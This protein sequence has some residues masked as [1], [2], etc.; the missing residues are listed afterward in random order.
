MLQCY[1]GPRHL[2]IE[3]TCSHTVKVFQTIIAGC[4]FATPA[5]KMLLIRTG[6][7]A[8]LLHPAITLRIYVDDAS[9]QWLGRLGPQVLKLVKAVQWFVQELEALKLV[10]NRTKCKCVASTVKL[11]KYLGP[12][13]KKLQFVLAR[14]G[15]NLGH[16]IAAATQGRKTVGARITIGLQ[17]Q[18]RLKKFIRAAGTKGHRVLCVGLNASALY[19]ASVTGASEVEL[20]RHRKAVARAMAV[21]PGHSAT[22][23]MLFSPS[24]QLDPIF[25]AS[26]PLIRNYIK[27]IWGH[28][29][30]LARLREGWN[31][32][33]PELQQGATW[34]KA[35]GP[36]RAVALT[37]ARLG[38]EFGIL[39]LVS[40]TGRIFCPTKDPPMAIMEAVRSSIRQWQWVQ[41][42]KHAGMLVRD[43]WDAP[44]R[45]L[46]S[47]G[48]LTPGESGALAVVVAADNWDRDRKF[49]A[50]V[51]HADRCIQCGA[52]DIYP[53]Q[54]Y[55]C[56]ALE[57]WEGIEPYAVHRATLQEE[58]RFGPSEAQERY[59][60]RG[61]LEVPLLAETGGQPVYQGSH[62]ICDT[63]YLD[64]SG[65]NPKHVE[66]LRLATVGC[67]W[68]TM[69]R[70]CA[71][72]RG[73]CL[74]PGNRSPGRRHG[75]F[76]VPW[77]PCSYKFERLAQGLLPT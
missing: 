45:Q 8:Q 30:S 33:E 34:R 58:R 27:A 24:A 13:I 29:C 66:L 72:R 41:V 52:H 50:G 68:P 20:G 75:P 57:A 9:L 32:I 48:K 19:T 54:L 49:K 6:A 37:F 5:L 44:L 17:R 39:Q 53:H 71:A 61:M 31:V 63:V 43:I 46:Q 1:G 73:P 7:R 11:E 55:H 51:A 12:H 10:L 40:P 42:Q 38:W 62:P 25:A 28:R 69:A 70:P 26:V 35:R 77:K 18:S 23:S 60:P 65:L 3:G 64:G 56:K 76:C 15:R 14:W 21:K 36:L 47:Q 22:A 59:H 74:A 16:D 4:T 67:R 2:D